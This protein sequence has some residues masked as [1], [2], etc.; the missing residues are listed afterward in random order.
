M[1]RWAILV[2][3]VA[4]VLINSALASTTICFLALIK[5]LIPFPAAKLAITHSAHAVMKVWSA[6]NAG[7][8]SLMNPQLV[9]QI[10]GMDNVR[11]GTWSLMISNHISW[12][13]IVVLFSVFRRT[14]PIPK[15]FL[16][17]ELLYVPFIGVA[18]WAVDMPFMKRYSPA[19]LLK[20]PEKRGSDLEATRRSCE[21]FR[22]TPTTVVN[23]VEGTRF[24]VDKQAKTKSPY[25][26]LLPPKPAGIAFALQAMQSQMKQVVDVTLCYPDNAEKPFRDLLQGKM[27]RIVV[28]IECITIDETLQGDYFNDPVYKRRFQRWLQDRWLHKDAYLDSMTETASAKASNS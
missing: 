17:K 12:A 6:V 28:N 7:L 18:C 13:D 10:E 24:T 23:F 5:L 14:M 21:K 27:Q 4:L 22:A 16:K 11:S 2:L 3:N 1:L 25:R 19:Y 15:F 9:W 8:L 20:H 26:H